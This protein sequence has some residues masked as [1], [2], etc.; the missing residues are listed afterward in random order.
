MNDA[1]RGLDNLGR[2]PS[3]EAKVA[4]EFLSSVYAELRKLA[5]SKMAGEKSGQTLQATAL[6]HEAWLRLGGDQQ[7]QW[8]CRAQFFAAAGEA[9]RRILIEQARRKSRQKRGSDNVVE[10]IHESQIELQAPSDEVLAIH[11]AL[12]HLAAEDPVAADVV[13]LRYFVGLSLPEVAEALSL[14]PRNT[15]RLWAF[16]RV[17]LKQWVQTDRAG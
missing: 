3:G 10:E 14:S 16:A 6:V 5:A 12:D 7:P 17:R 4:E 2:V 11:D 13:K 15:D 8:Q 9:M 1:S